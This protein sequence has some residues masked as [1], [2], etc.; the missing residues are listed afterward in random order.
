[1]NPPLTPPRRGTARTRTNSCS[2]PERGRRWVGSWRA[3]IR[4]RARIGTMNREK[5][6][7]AGR[8]P[9]SG[10]T[11]PGSWKACIRVCACIATMNPPLTPPRRGTDRTRTDACS[12]P[13]RGWG[14]VG[15]WRELKDS[16]SRA[17]EFCAGTRSDYW[18]QRQGPGRRSAVEAALIL[19]LSNPKGGNAGVSTSRKSP[20]APP[21]QKRP[22]RQRLGLDLILSNYWLVIWVPEV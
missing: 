4:F 10:G 22:K 11:A 3:S 19:L 8:T 14:W 2:P 12:P 6:R 13:G 21:K 16:L 20:P 9:K 7:Q 17:R 15:S 18:S 1:M 5:R